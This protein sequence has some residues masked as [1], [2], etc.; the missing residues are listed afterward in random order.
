VTSV[1]WRPRISCD[2][3]ERV[4]ADDQIG[5]GSLGVRRDSGGLG[6][7]EAH[8]QLARIWIVK[9]RLVD[10]RHDNLGLDTG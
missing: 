10:M 8:C 6:L 1:P 3:E 5:T 9:Q 4:A 7:R 2:L